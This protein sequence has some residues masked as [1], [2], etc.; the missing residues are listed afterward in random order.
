MFFVHLLPFFFI[1]TFSINQLGGLF[2]IQ[3][4]D[5][6]SYSLSI[7]HRALVAKGI[8]FQIYET[9][10][11]N[12]RFSEV[13]VRFFKIIFCPTSWFK[14]K[15]LDNLPSLSMSNLLIGKYLL[16]YLLIENLSN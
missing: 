10:T 15:Q 9:M 16:D 11:E 8:D 12:L 4:S 2:P 6:L 5:W 3:P 7:G 14:L 13:S 1:K